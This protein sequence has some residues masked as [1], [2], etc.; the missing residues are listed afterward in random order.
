MNVLVLA[1][2]EIVPEFKSMFKDSEGW[3]FADSY[4][5]ISSELDKAG[6]VFDFLAEE[7]PENLEAYLHRDGLVV[8]LSIPK[9]SLAE[10]QYF[11]GEA[12]CTFF[13]FN[14]LPTMLDRDRLEVSMLEE[15]HRTLLNDTCKSLGIETYVVEDRV[16]MVTPRV[17]CMII[18]EAFYTI[19]EGTASRQ[20]IDTAMKLGTNYPMGPF[21]WCSKMGL[22]NVY[23]LLEA[24]YNDTHDERYKICPLLKREYLLLS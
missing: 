10:L 1:R 20:D 7:S 22:D 6:V 23:E 4:A 21:E 2:E 12:A 13:G 19:Q 15:S 11:T 18:N 3:A 9:S 5:G 16:G 14:G 17:V 24:L 8:F